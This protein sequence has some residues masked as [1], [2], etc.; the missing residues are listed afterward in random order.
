MA[1]TW[2]QNMATEVFRAVVVLTWPDGRESSVT[3]GPYAASGAAAAAITNAR[4]Y[5]RWRS[6]GATVTGHVER[7][8][9][10]WASHEKRR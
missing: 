2:N 5:E 6:D 3:Y 9:T 10:V 7:A 8:E 4:N 1:R